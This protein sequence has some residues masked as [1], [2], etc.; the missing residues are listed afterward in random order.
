MLNGI[1]PDDHY[2]VRKGLSD[3][4]AGGSLN[5]NPENPGASSLSVGGEGTKEDIEL[6]T[7][8]SYLNDNS[9]SPDAI[10]YMW[11]DVEGYEARFVAGAH[12]TLSRINV[13]IFME[14]TPRF[15]TG[16]EGEFDLLINGLKEHFR[17]FI[18]AQDPGRGKMLIERLEE[19]KNNETLQWDLFLLKD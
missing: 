9:I 1:D 10:R 6:V 15:Y 12:E 7:F 13:P 4:C 5:Y 19:E 16:R 14:F 18:C 11:I 17:S 3:V 2:F 8:D